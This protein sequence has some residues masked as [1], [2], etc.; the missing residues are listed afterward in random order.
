MLNVN[1]GDKVKLVN[2]A[3]SKYYENNEFTVISEPYEICECLVV[4]IKCEETGKYFGGGS[5]VEKLLLIK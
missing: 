4:K 3:E 2:C 1:I 5:A